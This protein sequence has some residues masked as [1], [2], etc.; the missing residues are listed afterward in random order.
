MAMKGRYYDYLFG[1]RDGYITEYY[2]SYSRDD[3]HFEY[4]MDGSAHRLF[5]GNDDGVSIVSRSFYPGFVARYVKLE[6]RKCVNSMSLRW[7]IYGCTGT[8]AA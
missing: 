8:C 2:L 1:T 6:G 4:V 3:Q 7:E 5:S